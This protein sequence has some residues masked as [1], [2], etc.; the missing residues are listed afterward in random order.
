MKL[1]KM[2]HLGGGVPPPFHVQWR[3]ECCSIFTMETSVP[4]PLRPVSLNLPTGL[5]SD[6]R[7]FFFDLCQKGFGLIVLCKSVGRSNRKSSQGQ[8]ITKKM[9]VCRWQVSW[10]VGFLLFL[11][12]VIGDFDKR[13]YLKREHTLVKPYSGYLFFSI[14]KTY[15]TLNYVRS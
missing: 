10:I 8:I 13:D 5:L 3:Q 12:N 2:Y 9:D 6:K 7:I 4:H 14:V 1:W 15:K 11:S